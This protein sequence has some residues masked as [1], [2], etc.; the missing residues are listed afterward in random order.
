MRH[1]AT[2]KTEFDIEFEVPISLPEMSVLYQQGSMA[3]L[4]KSW[5]FSKVGLKNRTLPTI[6]YQTLQGCA[7]I[8][9]GKL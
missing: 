6:V 4:Y 5:K 7:L 2:L 1:S 9:Q 3:R 8:A